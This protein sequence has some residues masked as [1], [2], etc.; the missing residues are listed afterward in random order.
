MAASREQI[1]EWYRTYP[2]S[3][4]TCREFRHDERPF[5]VSRPGGLRGITVVTRKCTRCGREVDRFYSAAFARLGDRTVVRYQRPYLAPSGVGGVDKT[6]FA[7]RAIE[8]E[9]A[10]LEAEQAARKAAA[11]TPSAPTDNDRPPRPRTRK[12][13]QPARKTPPRAEFKQPAKV[14]PRPP[15]K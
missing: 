10:V 5:T 3:W 14:P 4:A 6:V 9:L 1:E 8:A 15:R 13:A 7:Q 12:S 2:P 11:S